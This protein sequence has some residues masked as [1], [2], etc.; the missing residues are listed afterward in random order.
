MLAEHLPFERLD[1]VCD[2]DP[3]PSVGWN[4]GKVE[5]YVGDE[6]LVPLYA[7]TE[8]KPTWGGLLFVDL[9]IDCGE[10]EEWCEAGIVPG[11]QWDFHSGIG[12]RPEPGKL[13]TLLVGWQDEPFGGV[14]SEEPLYYLKFTATKP[15]LAHIRWREL[16]KDHPEFWRRSEL[17]TDVK[18]TDG[19]DFF[20]W[21]TV[22]FYQSQPNVTGATY[23]ESGSVLVRPA[24]K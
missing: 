2:P 4:I 20:A 18:C 6:V 21:D 9:E 12:Y 19:S 10:N 11:P 3:L 15:G 1:A 16:P 17:L 24:R 14:S 22:D 23:V 7:D 13:N 8:G 5:A